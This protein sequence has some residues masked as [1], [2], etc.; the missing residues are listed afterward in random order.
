MDVFANFIT[1]G[2]G[3]GGDG[4]NIGAAVGMLARLAQDLQG[5]GVESGHIFFRLIGFQAAYFFPRRALG[6]ASSYTATKWSKSSL[7]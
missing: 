7:V 2:G 5:F 3:S 6:C 4:G 1:A